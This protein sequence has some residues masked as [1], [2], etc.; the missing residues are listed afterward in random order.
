[1]INYYNKYVKYKKKYL[2]AK[3]MNV[4]GGEENIEK[5]IEK[6][7]GIS[8]FG[9]EEEKECVEKECSEVDKVRVKI[10]LRNA[11]ERDYNIELE[12]LLDV[13]DSIGYLTKRIKETFG[14]NKIKIFKII[15]NGENIWNLYSKN[16]L[17]AKFE[18]LHDTFECGANISL[19]IDILSP[20]QKKLNSFAFFQCDGLSDYTMKDILDK[21]KLKYELVLFKIYDTDGMCEICDETTLIIKNSILLIEIE[22]PNICRGD[23]CV[24]L[25]MPHQF[26]CSQ[27]CMLEAFGNR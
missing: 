2:Q 3:K 18:T 17:S 8:F 12:I 15:F 1:M 5:N 4:G 23:R 7:W 22:E 16:K 24:N 10:T 25:I 6:V 27:K 21:I 11:E 14:E 19:I 9:E 26:Y 13:N 20:P